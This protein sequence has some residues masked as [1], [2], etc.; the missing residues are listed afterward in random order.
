VSPARRFKHLTTIVN[1]VEARISVGLENALE[2]SEMLPRM[3]T[4]AI[5]AKREPDRRR[6]R[7][8]GGPFVTHVCPQSAGLGFAAPGCE[9]R[10]RRIVR[11]NDVRRQD[12]HVQRIG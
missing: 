8:S 5:G 9:H 7:T 4:F 10:K 2:T 3:V 11:M 1:L 12:V 6:D